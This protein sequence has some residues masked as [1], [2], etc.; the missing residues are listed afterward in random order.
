MRFF[1]LCC[2][3]PAGLI[4]SP[5]RIRAAMSN[6]L[7]FGGSNSSLVFIHPDEVDN[8]RGKEGQS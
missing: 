5:A 3:R 4:V 8:L 1:G 6:S 7:G 2:F